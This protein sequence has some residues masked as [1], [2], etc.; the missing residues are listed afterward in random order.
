V[1]NAK[2]SEAAAFTQQPDTSIAKRNVT[3]SIIAM[4]AGL[5]AAMLSRLLL[6]E[7]SIQLDQGSFPRW[8]VRYEAFQRATTSWPWNAVVCGSLLVVLLLLKFRKSAWG[9]AFAL[10]GTLGLIAARAIG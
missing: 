6:P 3:V 4:F 9:A 8:L 7:V 10:G 2:R 5:V 1:I